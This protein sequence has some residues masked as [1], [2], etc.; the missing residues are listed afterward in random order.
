V[1]D[2]RLK[3]FYG[4]IVRRE[5]QDVEADE[6]VGWELRLEQGSENP[7][8]YQLGLTLLDPASEEHPVPCACRMARLVSVLRI[9]IRKDPHHFAGSG[10]LEADP[11]PRL[12]NW[13]LNNFF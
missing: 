8:H 6:V 13:H 4:N 12:Q 11:D 3:I 5:D 1:I 2:L 9:R 10:I 7:R